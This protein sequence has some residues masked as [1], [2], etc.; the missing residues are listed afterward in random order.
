MTPEIKCNSDKAPSPPSFPPPFSLFCKNSK[1]AAINC[2]Y[3]F[4]TA[5][6]NQIPSLYGNENPKQ[7]SSIF[8]LSLINRVFSLSFSLL[9]PSVRHVCGCYCWEKLVATFSVEIRHH[10]MRFPAPRTAGEF[11]D[12]ALNLAIKSPFSF[13]SS[14]FR[15][16]FF[17]AAEIIY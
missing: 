12:L 17:C 9:P 6:W 11:E 3:S 10:N 7:S 5:R 16:L 15:E 13:F 8:S 4:A 1:S 2:S 14:F